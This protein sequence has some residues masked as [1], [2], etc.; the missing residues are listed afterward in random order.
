MFG[1]KAGRRDR[2]MLFIQYQCRYMYKCIIIDKI[3]TFTV[4]VAFG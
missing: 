3:S 1:I 4:F 2:T